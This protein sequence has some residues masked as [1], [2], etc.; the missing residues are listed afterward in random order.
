MKI[1]RLKS[2]L[3]RFRKKYVNVW[4]LVI[5]FN[6]FYLIIPPYSIF[7][8]VIDCI[9][10]LYAF[11]IWAANHRADKYRRIA[12]IFMWKNEKLKEKYFYIDSE[13]VFLNA[14]ARANKYSSDET[15][16]ETFFEGY[17]HG[18]IDAKKY[19]YH[20]TPIYNER[21]NRKS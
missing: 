3:R 2:R 17:M 10:I 7:E 5:I 20:E 4:L 12:N 9:G 8:A 19:G 13:E 15:T 6:V 16:R 1:Y 14:N 11:G 18:F 21:K